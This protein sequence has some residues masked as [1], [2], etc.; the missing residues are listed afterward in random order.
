[1]GSEAAGREAKATGVADSVEVGWEEAATV[2]ADSA[3]AGWGE[4][5]GT[6][7]A[8]SAA[9]VVGWEEVARG[10]VGWA[11]SCGAHTRG[12]ARQRT[13]GQRD[14]PRSLAARCV[15]QRCDVTHMHVP[16]VPCGYILILVTSRADLEGE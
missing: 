13:N 7:E 6:A 2:E 3:V 16:W 14:A 8:G 9:V 11:R 12:C 5:E 10:V 15:G 1:M 4:E